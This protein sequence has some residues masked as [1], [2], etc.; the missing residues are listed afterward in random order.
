MDLTLSA[1]LDQE[2]AAYRRARSVGDSAA[3]SAFE[4]AH[5]LSQAKLGAHLRVHWLMLCLAL[6]HHNLREIVGQSVRLVLAPI[7]SL[8]G[9]M[10]S[11]N[12]GR[13]N[14]SAFAPMPFPA[15]LNTALRERTW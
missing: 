15:D 10:P 2:L 14:V 13:S 1:L 8:S 7:G 12:T 5:V 6:R 3:W 9:R 4:R 11:V